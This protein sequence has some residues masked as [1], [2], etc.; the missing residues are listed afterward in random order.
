ML[1]NRLDPFPTFD[2][3]TVSYLWWKSWIHWS[4]SVDPDVLLPLL[5]DDDDVPQ[6]LFPLLLRLRLPDSAGGSRACLLR[7]SVDT[8]DTKVSLVLSFTSLLGISFLVSF[9]LRHGTLMANLTLRILKPYSTYSRSMIV[10][11]SKPTE[12]SRD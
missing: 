8:F 7:S 11:D 2:V 5:C 3:I 12:R 6:E 4:W 10:E 9:F 1:L